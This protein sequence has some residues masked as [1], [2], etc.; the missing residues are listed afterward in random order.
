MTLFIKDKQN[1]QSS[2]WKN[3]TSWDVT[4][5]PYKIYALF[6][7]LTK[8]NC[9]CMSSKCIIFTVEKNSDYSN[10][11]YSSASHRQHFNND[12]SAKF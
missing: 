7:K 9:E 6:F 2:K 4:N 11:K 12:L 5:R 1:I 3:S 8:N 10:V